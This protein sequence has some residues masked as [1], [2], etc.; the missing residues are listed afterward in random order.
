MA[1]FIVRLSATEIT[2]NTENTKDKTL[3]V[4]LLCELGVLCG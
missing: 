3:P 4:D 1:M 2:E